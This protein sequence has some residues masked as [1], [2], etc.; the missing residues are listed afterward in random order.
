MSI[1]HLHSKG[2]SPNNFTNYFKQGLNLPR[3]TKVRML[4]YSINVSKSE[5]EEITATEGNNKYMVIIGNQL[6]PAVVNPMYCEIKEA[7]YDLSVAPGEFLN[8]IQESWDQQALLCYPNLTIKPS[9]DA[10][11]GTVQIDGVPQ[12]P[13]DTLSPLF[14]PA[15]PQEYIQQSSS[16]LRQSTATLVYNAQSCDFFGPDPNVEKEPNNMACV[17][18]EQMAF[19]DRLQ[20]RDVGLTTNA[21]WA[22]TWALTWDATSSAE[23]LAWTG[24]VMSHRYLFRTTPGGLNNVPL[25]FGEDGGESSG[26]DTSRMNMNRSP[27]DPGMSGISANMNAGGETSNFYEHGWRLIYD[28]GAGGEP[29][30]G[31]A[32]LQLQY[33]MPM[34]RKEDVAPGPGFANSKG[35]M[36]WGKPFATPNFAGPQPGDGYLIGWR[37][38]WDIDSISYY[39]QLAY[40]EDDGAT[41]GLLHEFA[42]NQDLPPGKDEGNMI[43]RSAPLYAVTQSTRF[44]PVTAPSPQNKIILKSQSPYNQLPIAPEPRNNDVLAL[45]VNSLFTKDKA[46]YFGGGTGVDGSNAIRKSQIHANSQ[47]LLGLKDKVYFADI[48][49]LS[50]RSDI[51]L[52]SQELM[53]ENNQDIIFTSPSLPI[54]GRLGF[55]GRDAPV[56]AVGRMKSIFND[57]TETGA[58]WF[59]YPN[60]VYVSLNNDQ[61]IQQNE[62]EIRC[63][64]ANNELLKGLE[65]YT[66]VVLEFTP[67]E[68]LGVNENH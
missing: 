36:V 31:G 24:G 40:S 8:A 55:N 20:G 12:S 58:Y 63:V 39:S 30:G 3:N 53:Y 54:Q 61:P 16:V 56:L 27:A 37:I 15:Q 2:S 52:G 45:Y 62:I 28:D 34:L 46:T 57:P 65:N 38:C 64:D 33:G 14:K 9:Y 51:A 35:E 6:K 26:K 22:T 60:P 59:N 68:N 7:S 10:G 47:H 1:V 23:S 29:V 18:A 50:I 42:C 25:N 43:M 11:T 4:G 66:S 19:P 17:S 44:K 41:W 49:Q 67:S 21:D 5:K 48:G 32:N 13:L